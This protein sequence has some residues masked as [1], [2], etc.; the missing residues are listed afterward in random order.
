ME[1]IKCFYSSVSN[2]G[3][4]FESTDLRSVGSDTVK[5]SWAGLVFGSEVALGNISLVMCLDQSLR[6]GCVDLHT[7]I[8]T[9]CF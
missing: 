5:H 9:Q 3:R 2:T 1:T 8:E 7:A 6:A 4:V